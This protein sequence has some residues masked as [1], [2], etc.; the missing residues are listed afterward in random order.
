M[1]L[2]VTTYVPEGIVMTFNIRQ[3][4]TLEGKTPDSKDLP[5]YD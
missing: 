3:S 2:F 1:S 4:I 5:K